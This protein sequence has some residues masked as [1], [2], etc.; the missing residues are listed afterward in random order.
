MDFITSLPVTKAGCDSIFVVVDRF[1]KRSHFVAHRMTDTAADVAL[2]FLREVVRLHGMPISIVSDRDSRFMSSFW[3]SLL[4][5]LGVSRDASSSMHPQSDGQTE[6]INRILEETL[7]HYVNFRRDDWDVLLCCAEFAYNSSLHSAIKMSPFECDIGFTPST[8]WTWTD[9]KS[10]KNEA[11]IVLT[12]KLKLI[13]EFVRSSLKSSN[14]RMKEYADRKRV[15]IEFSVGDLVLVDRT[16][17][18]IDAF[19]E[20]KKTKFLPK[21]VGPFVIIE[22]IGKLAYRLDI[23]DR[24]RA[25]NVFHVSNL[26]KYLTSSSTKKKITMPDAIVVDGQEE[27]EVEEIL[28]VKSTRNH[29][30]YLVKWKGYPLHDATW[31]PLSNLA[32]AKESVERFERKRLMHRSV[33]FSRNATSSLVGE[34]VVVAHELLAQSIVLYDEF[35][36]VFQDTIINKH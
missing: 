9:R 15:D 10:V 14:A 16:R 13:G 24:S 6:R 26:K 36:R 7:R 11:A 5:L 2:L 31:E 28:D 27:F 21:Y 22:R 20:F 12:D 18:S 19:K 17:F 4:T 34:N 32:N 33:H 30:L 25:H 29:K 35:E 3:G 1:S 23:P 8:F